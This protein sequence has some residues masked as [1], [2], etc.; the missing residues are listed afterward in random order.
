[1]V[2]AG[3]GDGRPLVRDAR[4]SSRTLYVGV[5]ID[6]RTMA[7]SARRAAAKPARG[8]CPNARFVVSTVEAWPDE[9]AEFADLATVRYPWG[10]LLRGVLGRDPAVLAGLARML[11]P[12]GLLEVTLSLVGR[13]GIEMPGERELEI[14]CS[15]T[16][17]ALLENR[18]ATPAEIEANATT[19][20]RRLGVG[21]G[22]IRPVTRLLA[23]RR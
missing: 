3:T 23:V 14:A 19:W 5:E 10:S 13:D 11:R 12:G 21:K 2:D 6:A 1:V 8:G 7:D 17:L 20:S 22:P 4:R 16:G 18:P 15:A 9:G